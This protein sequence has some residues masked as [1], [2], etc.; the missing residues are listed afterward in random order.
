MHRKGNCSI[1][2]IAYTIC[3][4]DCDSGEI[5]R[6]WLKL[7]HIV[8][9]Q[10]FCKT[11]LV[12]VLEIIRSFSYHGVA[13]VTEHDCNHGTLVYFVE[14]SKSSF[15]CISISISNLHS[16]CSITIGQ[17]MKPKFY[18]G[19]EEVLRT[20]RIISIFTSRDTTIHTAQQ[21]SLISAGSSTTQMMSG[22]VWN[23]LT[24]SNMNHHTIIDT[25]FN[26][27]RYTWPLGVVCCVFIEVSFVYGVVPSYTASR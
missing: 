27:L 14:T 18:Q 13:Q 10:R 16:L 9:N 1:S 23:E 26:V 2:A 8:K 4:R 11:I 6:R 25:T 7:K 3:A 22:S 20:T 17:N 21:W 24:F 15:L 19:R 5:I 12:A